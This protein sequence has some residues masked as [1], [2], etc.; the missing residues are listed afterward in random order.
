MKGTG[1]AQIEFIPQNGTVNGRGRESKGGCTK[2]DSA[3][4]KFVAPGCVGVWRRNE[5]P[6]RFWSKVSF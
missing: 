5:F 1:E 2:L 3:M 4:Q 6:S